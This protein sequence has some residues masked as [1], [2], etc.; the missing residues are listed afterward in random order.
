MEAL[1]LIHQAFQARENAYCPYSNFKVGAA[2]LLKNGQ[3]IVGANVENAAYGSSM[4]AERNAIFQVYSQGYRKQDIEAL[5]IVADTEA[6]ITPCG[7]CRQV[8]V[9]LLDSETPI[10]LANKTSYKQTTIEKLLPKSFTGAY[11]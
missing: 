1:E 4:C 11:L 2:V 10:F 7:S 5:A 9:E 8:L 6:V 3:Y